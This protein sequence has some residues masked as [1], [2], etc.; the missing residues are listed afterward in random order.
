MECKKCGRDLTD[1]EYK[2]VAE[3]PF[4]LECFQALMEPPAQKE[5]EAAATAPETPAPSPTGPGFRCQVCESEIEKGGGHT[6]LGFLFCDA[7][8]ENLVKKP[9]LPPR[10]ESVEE[11]AEAQ[12]AVAQ[13]RLHLSSPIQCNAC[14][15]QIP[16][17]G[18]KEFEDHR[19][20]PDCYYALPEIQ[21]QK[22]KPF[23]AT[24]SHE[25]PITEKDKAGPT[26]QAC[27]REVLP[28]NLKT[29]EGFEICR[30][31]LAADP[32]TALDIARTRH[33]KA[34]EKMRRQLDV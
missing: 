9:V 29:I 15:R 18:S 22:P 33:R 32:D 2:L 23:P 28:Q 4:C 8:Y 13:V 30:A 11:E 10:P 1:T 12:P 14:G 5:E 17:M 21:A 7:C 34:L 26:C 3:W 20:C 19:Y 27:G 31:C 6:M 24:V 25:Q 16:L